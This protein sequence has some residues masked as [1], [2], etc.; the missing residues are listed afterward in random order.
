MTKYL[1]LFL[2][3]LLAGCGQPKQKLNLLIWSEYLD[4]KIVANFE[5]EFDC[6]V[7]VDFCDENET[8][9]AKLSS[10][11]SGIYDIILPSPYIIPAM[12]GRGVLSPLRF[13]NLPNFKNVDPQFTKTEFDPENRYTV[14]LAMGTTGVLIRRPAGKVVEESWGLI[15]DPAR[16]PGPFLLIEDPRGCIDAAMMFKGHQPNGTDPKEL[17]EARDLLVEVKKRSLGFAPFS[18]AVNR[19]LSKEAVMAMAPSNEAA[20]VLKEDPELYFFLPREGTGKFVDNLAIPNHAPHRDLAEKFINY[21]LEGRVSAQLCNFNHMGS[22]NKAALDLI[23]PEDR[24][25]PA[26][27]PSPEVIARLWY[28][29]DLGDKQKLY[30]ELWTQI[31]AK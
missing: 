12:V 21:M 30:D 27:Y 25:N 31:K 8:M 17:T 18:A 13:E 11:G 19:V 20:R 15:F 14:P 9:L 22:L 6:K 5:R 26:I 7:N 10:G 16:Q 3:A 23:N 4:P 29:K 2:V 1:C 24:K 28:G